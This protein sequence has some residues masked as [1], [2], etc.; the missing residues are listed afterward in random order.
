MIVKNPLAEPLPEVLV[1]T[2]GTSA[3][4]TRAVRSG[5]LRKIGP[6]LYS[7]NRV[8][9]PESIVARNQWIVLG[10]LFPGAVIGYRTALNTRPT[11]GGKLFLVGGYDRVLDLPGLTVRVLKGAGALDGDMRFGEALHI[12]SEARAILDCLSVKRVG[13]ESPALSRVE[14]EELL[15]RRLAQRGEQALNSIRDLARRIAPAMGRE[16]ELAA[17]DA[18]IG[19]L[20]G[21]R[22]DRLHAA[23]ALARAAGEPYDSV[24]IERF[25]RLVAALREWGGV[26]RP[27][28]DLAGRP[29]ENLAFFDAYFSNFIEGTEF[30]VEEAAEIV[31][32][33]KIPRARPADAH[34]VLGTYR[35][36]ANG[37]EMRRTA[38]EWVDAPERFV[39]VLRS[40]HAMILGERP[41]AR[42]GMLKEMM[43]RAGD[44]FFVAPEL[45]RGTLRRGLEM[46]P[47]LT[48]PF[49]RA[50]YMMFLVSEVHPFDDGNGRVARAMMNA[51]LIAG[52][53]RR[54][55]IPTAFRAD[56]LG[57]LRRLSRAGDA[58][59]LIQ[60]LDFAQRFTAAID[61]ADFDAAHAVLRRARAFDTA[62]DAR[63]RMPATA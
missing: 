61:F 15:E 19:S 13:A 26:A 63:L 30:E 31:F 50:A 9:T 18:L 43:N 55:L 23:A 4:I 38:L 22:T 49:Q 47:A 58:D 60:V 1:S 17:L 62:D 45:V 2:P 21:T 20:L 34:D 27:D 14:I 7:P 24:R 37:Q 16:R 33:R 48:E 57:A 28:P 29:F 3:W 12:A 54:I 56:Y 41:E 8:D 40:R 10:V 32:Q 35:L 25:S 51:E 11:P 6:R 42:P 44:T 52:G 59:A 53:E 39:E 36:V 46:F 5:K